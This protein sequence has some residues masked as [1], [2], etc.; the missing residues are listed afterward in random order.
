VTRGWKVFVLIFTCF[1]WFMSGWGFSESSVAGYCRDF[2]K[3]EIKG[4]WYE[5]R[6][7]DVVK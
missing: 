2:G 5:C 1:C 3:T 7:M 4:K 6:P